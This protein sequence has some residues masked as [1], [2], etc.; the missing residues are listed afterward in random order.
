M[1]EVILVTEGDEEIG[2]MEKMEA[3]R[4]GVLHRAFS[5]FVFDKSGRMLLQ[6]RA[7]YKYHGALLWSNT[8]CSHPYPGEEVAN[9]AARRLEEEMGFTTG[10]N[11]IFSFC[12]NET[13]ENNLIEHEYDHVFVGEFDGEI[14]TNENEV[15][16][17]SYRHMRDIK[18][19]LEKNPSDFTIWFKIVFPRIEQ[20][21]KENYGA[22][23]IN[24]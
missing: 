21:W 4:R 9:A 16:D 17:F 11:K 13:V 1:E 20:W 23:F 3:H 12:Y 14:K 5:I 7:A 8:C 10:L 2:T 6:K 19:D 24:Q 15:D 18:K 22:V